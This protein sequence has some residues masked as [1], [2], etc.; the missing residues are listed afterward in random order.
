MN[1]EKLKLWSW[2]NHEDDLQLTL[3]GN[4]EEVN[5]SKNKQYYRV[6]RSVGAFQHTLSLPVDVDRDGITAN[7][8]NKLLIIQI[9]R[10]ALPK[11]DVKHISISS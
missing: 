6:E 4:K 9:P 8:R 7:V 11:D 2:F 3:K 5:E 10:K 1:I